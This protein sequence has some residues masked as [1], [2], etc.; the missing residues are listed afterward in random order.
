MVYRISRRSYDYV[1]RQTGKFKAGN[2]NDNPHD[3]QA[4]MSS[5]AHRI[6][7][8]TYRVVTVIQ[9]EVAEVEN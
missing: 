6:T 3:I 4:G 8:R 5:S 9:I 1:D 2:A 7:S